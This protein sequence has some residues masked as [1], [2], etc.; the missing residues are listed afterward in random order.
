[1]DADLQASGESIADL[2]PTIAKIQARKPV[3]VPAFL[4]AEEMQM[5]ID[6]GPPEGL[7]VISQGD[8]PDEAR[9]LQDAVL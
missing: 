5:I 6:R 4:S 2:I 7:G 1:M 8:S 3:I 9:R